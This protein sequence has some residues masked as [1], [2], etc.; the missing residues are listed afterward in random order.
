MRH[1][2]SG[3]GIDR[4]FVV[5]SGLAGFSLAASLTR[6]TRSTPRFPRAS[7]RAALEF[8][9]RRAGLGSAVAPSVHGEGDRGFVPRLID[10]AARRGFAAYR[11][12]GRTAGP[13]CTVWMPPA[14]FGC[15]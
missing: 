2:V 14:C 12:T 15:A 4:P 9:T 1:S 10:I 5:T 3:R 11:A 7:E 6:T 13:L 8:T